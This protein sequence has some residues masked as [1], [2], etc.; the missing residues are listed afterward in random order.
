MYFTA[1]KSGKIVVITYKQTNIII[2]I[3]MILMIE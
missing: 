1:D 2:M 3:L